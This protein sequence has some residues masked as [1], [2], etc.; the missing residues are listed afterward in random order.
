MFEPYY[1]IFP[2]IRGI[3]AGMEYYT[4]MCPLKLIPKIFLYDEEELNPEL[5]AQR[6]LNKAR[7]PEIASYLIEN[8][9]S[10]VLSSLTASIDGDIEFIPISRPKIL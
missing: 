10:Y 5:R 8:S 6:T 7:V 3:Q 1:Y 9:K 2:A 4:S